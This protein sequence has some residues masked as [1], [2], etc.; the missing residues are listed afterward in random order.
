MRMPIGGQ[1]G[2]FYSSV[3]GRRWGSFVALVLATFSVYAA[4]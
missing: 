4:T 3:K 2:G 1:D